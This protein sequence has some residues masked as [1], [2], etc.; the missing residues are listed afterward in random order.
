MLLFYNGDSKTVMFSPTSPLSSF[1][2]SS[3]FDETSSPL[4]T[5]FDG[6]PPSPALWTAEIS[7][8][9]VSGGAGLGIWGMGPGLWDG[10]EMGL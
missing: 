3:L 8:D 4:D 9:T 10:I 5:P 2:V 6:D 1:P 7:F